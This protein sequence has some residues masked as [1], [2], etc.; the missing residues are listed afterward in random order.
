MVIIVLSIF[1][2]VCVSFLLMVIFLVRDSTVENVLYLVDFS[3]HCGNKHLKAI[4]QRALN[5]CVYC[6]YCMWDV[7]KTN[8]CTLHVCKINVLYSIHKTNE[9]ISAHTQPIISNIYT[10]TIEL[11]LYV[12]FFLFKI[13]WMHNLH[14]WGT[15]TEMQ[16]FLFSAHANCIVYV[17]YEMH[18]HQL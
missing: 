2:C 15:I 16:R 14:N 8:E 9:W 12:Q 17:W 5:T 11:R 3:L 7:V 10:N 13:Q 1:L 18:W 6:M 4:E